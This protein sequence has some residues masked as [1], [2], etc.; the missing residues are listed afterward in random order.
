M[1]S[2]RATSA[3]RTQTKTKKA[4]KSVAKY[5]ERAIIGKCP[6]AGLVSTHDAFPDIT[7]RRQWTLRCWK[8]ALKDADEWIEISDRMTSLVKNCG[9]RICGHIISCV[10]PQII[11]MYGFVRKTT[12]QVVAQNCTLHNKLILKG[13]FHYKDPDTL[14]SFA[15]NKIISEILHLA[16]FEDKHL[17]GPLLSEHFNPISL[18]TLV[19]FMMIDFC[20]HEWST[21]AFLQATFYEKDVI[22]THKIYRAEVEAWSDMNLTV[23]S[24]IRKKL[25]TCALHNSGVVS[26]QAAIVSGLV[27]EAK[28]QVQ[29]ELDGRTGDTDNELSA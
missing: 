7:L 2:S 21:G 12:S 6:K 24:N 29:T 26:K 22:H 9:S 8:Q 28:D 25:F 19:I 14:S 20:L 1:L 5:Q 13:A 27:G 17:Q 15:Q 3:A 16:W 4:A 10:W 23:T 11:A 18:E